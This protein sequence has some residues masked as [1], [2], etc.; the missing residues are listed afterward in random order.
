MK[1]G[2]QRKNKFKSAVFKSAKS[3]WNSFPIILGTILLTSLTALIPHEFYARVFSGRPLVNSIL[4]AVV[5]SISAGNPVTSYIF[6][7]EFL[8]QGVGLLTI[9]AFLV[10]WVTVGVIQIPAESIMLGK[11]FSIIRN[12]T[13]FVLA[14]VVAIITILLMGGIW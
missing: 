9:T 3:L 1:K 11:R 10:A 4:G 8:K 7:G 13:S 12:V 14:I 5:G 2:D 6:G